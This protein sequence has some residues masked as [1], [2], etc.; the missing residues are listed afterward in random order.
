MTF[1]QVTDEAGNQHT[2]NIVHIVE[3]VETHLTEIRQGFSYQGKR[4]TRL[5]LVNHSNWLIPQP[6]EE[7]NAL[8]EKARYRS[9]HHFA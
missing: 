5:Y 7:L 3:M 8:L 2:V 6:L 9:E 4:A 1:I